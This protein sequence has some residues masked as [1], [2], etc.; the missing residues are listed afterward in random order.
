[1]KQ[2]CLQVSRNK[3][4]VFQE[5]RIKLTVIN[6]DKHEITKVK[7]DGCE[8]TKGIRCDY[9][10]L[11]NN[12]EYFIELK[13]QDINHAIKQLGASI[14]QLNLNPDIKIGFIICQRSNKG[15]ASIMNATKKFK[16]KYGFNLIIQS[17]QFKY[18]LGK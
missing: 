2:E 1:M 6:K 13:G 8:I 10:L 9:L 17:S 14:E 7:I 5:N 12:L 18:K 3:L 16:K 11:S 15:A 4:I